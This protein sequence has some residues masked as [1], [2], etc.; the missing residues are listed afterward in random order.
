MRRLTL[1]LIVLALAG[2][3]VWWFAAHRATV[4]ARARDNQPSK[5]IPVLLATATKQDVPIYLDGLGTAQASASVIVRAQADGTLQE[6]RFKEGQ[7]VKVGDVLAQI[8]PR[9]YRAT[10]DQFVAKKAQDQ[11]NLAN[12]R[13]DLARYA[14]LAANAYTSTQTADT[15]RATVAQDEAVVSQ[16]QAQI[17]NA[18]VQLAYTTIVSPIDGRTGIRQVDAGNIVR[19]AD[20]NGIVTV[21]TLRPIAVTFS[22]P[23]QQL[24]EVTAAMA[25]AP[26]TPLETL[27]LPQG[28]SSDPNQ[29]ILDH[30]TLAVLDN[31]VDATTGT[32]RLKA[33]FPNQRLQLWPGAFVSVR[34]RVRVAKGAVV[35]PT[36]AVQRG[37]AG[38]Y[39]YVVGDDLLA[40]RRAVTITH[41]DPGGSIVGAGLEAGERVVTDGA[42]RLN[43]RM[44]VVITQPPD[45]KP[46]AAPAA[47]PGQPGHGRAPA[48]TPTSAA[49]SSG[50]VASGA[51]G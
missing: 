6:V 47:A 23:Q 2:G 1:I 28:V 42:S 51:A 32:I 39:V 15:Q 49:P 24:R 3:G 44:K 11:A 31:A 36:A 29:D 37:P 5:D 18:R 12:A 34:L 10:L 30:G 13:V 26:G 25:D 4:A 16:D 40:M 46:D 48:S 9:L 41:D 43:D 14:K 33:M 38:A 19:A 27:A 35:I 17:D 21:A 8:D 22:L 20:V 45:A 7:D 50:T